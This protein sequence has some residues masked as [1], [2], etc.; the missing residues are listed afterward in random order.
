MR[1]ITFLS[2]FYL[3]MLLAISPLHAQKANLK[4]VIEQKYLLNDVGGLKLASQIEKHYNKFNNM[5]K[6]EVFYPV[7]MPASGNLKMDKKILYSFD[8]RG[9]QLGTMEY[10]GDNIL[11]NETKIYWD[12][13]D[14][15]SKVEE[16]QYSNGGEAS[17]VTTYLLE[18]DPMGNR[19]REIYYT[20]E[21]VQEQSKEWFYN[22]D[23]E[24]VK[25]IQ[26][27]EKKNQPIKK[28]IVKY[29]RDKKGDLTKATTIE[30]INGKEYRKDLQFF[31]NNQVVRW[32]KYIAGKFES[33]F[34]NEYRDTVVIR[35]T[36]RN[37]RKVISLEKAQREQAL[38]DKKSAKAN[39]RNSEIWVTN[40]EYDAAGNLVISTQSINNKVVFITQYEYDTYG[41]CERILKTNKESNSKEEE[42]FEYDERGNVAKRTLL[43]DGQ[44]LAQEV[45]TYEYYPRD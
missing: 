29:E 35:T 32:R 30:N 44:I 42:L 2:I 5:I 14:N 26:I 34:V 10:N 15:R 11:E 36:R 6:Q 1:K 4:T 22:K 21:G 45:F 7:G 33:E 37:T 18:Y 20:N 9:R 38:N 13:Q 12:D 23:E 27:I 17:T 39:K 16:I 43:K 19:K 41:N 31:S 3:L 8:N 28:N 25:T 40:S 24:V